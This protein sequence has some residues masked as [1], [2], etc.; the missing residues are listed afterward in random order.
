MQGL[1][2]WY[3]FTGNALDSSGNGNNLALM[4]NTAL[5]TD[6][7]GVANSAY[8]LD[9]ND[10]ALV[11]AAA[12]YNSSLDHTISLWFKSTDSTKEQQVLINTNPHQIE[13]FVYKSYCLPAVES[14]AF[15][16]GNGVNW[17]TVGAGGVCDAVGTNWQYD[18]DP[19]N[20]ITLR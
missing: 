14:F 7:F 11:T 1:L 20:G 13:A 4:G 9:G 16:L 10:D 19:R 17:F 6:R 8:R 2:A 18:V 15:A 5:T 12:Y 3:P